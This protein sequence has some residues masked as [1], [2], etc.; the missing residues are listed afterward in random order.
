M[1]GIGARE[2]L[3]A[4]ARYVRAPCI[5]LPELS[6]RKLSTHQCPAVSCTNYGSMPACHH[7][8]SAESVAADSLSANEH[9]CATRNAV[10]PG[11]QRQ[12]ELV[13]AVTPSYGASVCVLCRRAVCIR[14]YLCRYVSYRL[15]D[16]KFRS[17][18]SQYSRCVARVPMW[19]RISRCAPRKACFRE[20]SDCGRDMRLGT[21]FGNKVGG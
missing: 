15:Q 14:L 5:T 2:R 1:F 9:R 18:R 17:N 6:G 16:T 13:W 12:P 10:K 7:R 20:K 8:Q 11:W 21:P 4:V 3:R 19:S